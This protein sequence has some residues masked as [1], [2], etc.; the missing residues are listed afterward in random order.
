MTGPTL[1]ELAAHPERAQDLPA[2]TAMHFLVQLAA[3]HPVLLA[4]CAVAPAGA[5]QERPSPSPFQERYLSVEEVC[6]RFSV[7][8]RWLYRHK[9]H[10]PH[11]QPTR[12][13]L[14]FPEHKL[15]QWFAGRNAS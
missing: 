15:T 3:L 1:D 12:K 14:L 5:S 2:P 9:K 10:L 11:S 13:T 6:E 8:P 7:T 4:R